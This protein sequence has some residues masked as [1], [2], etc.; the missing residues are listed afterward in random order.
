[1]SV[2]LYSP[3]HDITYAIDGGDVTLWLITGGVLVNVDMGVSVA[4]K[5]FCVGVI[6]V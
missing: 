1:M 4:F 5:L 2:G 3:D 6:V